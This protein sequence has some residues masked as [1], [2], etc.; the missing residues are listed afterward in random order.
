MT[1][2][3]DHEHWDYHIWDD[4]E[5]VKWL[6]E[7]ILLQISDMFKKYRSSNVHLKM[8]VDLNSETW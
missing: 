8:E 7:E 4:M 6:P 1:K 3:R 2:G 5:I